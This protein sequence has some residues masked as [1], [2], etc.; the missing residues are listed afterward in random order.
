MKGKEV[1]DLGLAT[2]FCKSS[3]LPVLCNQLASCK[4]AEVGEL[5]DEFMRESGGKGGGGEEEHQLNIV[6]A[7][8]EKAGHLIGTFTR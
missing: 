4:P 1:S 3:L 8:A 7:E 2:H 6:W 5:L